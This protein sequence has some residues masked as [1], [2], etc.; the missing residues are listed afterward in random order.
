MAQPDITATER[1]GLGY[2]TTTFNDPTDL[3]VI[4]RKWI[5]GDG[6]V[7][8]GEGLAS[9]H[10]TYYYPGKYKVILIAQTDS[11]QFTVKK[12]DFITIDIYKPVTNF[13]IAQSFDR[14]SGQY[15]RFYFDQ[16]LFLVFEDNTKIF[17]SREKVAE[18]NKW[19]FVN[20]DRSSHK[21]WAGGFSYYIKEL[22]VIVFDNNNPLSVTES[23]TDI[24][25]D[26]TMKIDEFR[27]WSKT[28]S[29]IPF[30]TEGRGKAGYL[31]TL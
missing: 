23:K 8:E 19:M 7:V 6:V 3:I 29:P 25:P 10:H 28:K 21:M 18:I 11:E 30:Y 2:L 27:V 15:W 24:L 22:R 1:I 9:I 4:N 5:F 16:D 14:D 12:E 31:N 17:R 13:I 20:F 26:S